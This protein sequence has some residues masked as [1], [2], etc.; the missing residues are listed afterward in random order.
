MGG[1]TPRGGFSL[2]ASIA[3][4]GFTRERLAAV[5]VAVLVAGC[6][7]SGTAD[8]GA[9]PEAGSRDAGGAI[10]AGATADAGADGGAD[11]GAACA[12]GSFTDA[13]FDEC[14][15]NV[16]GATF[17]DMCNTCADCIPY[18]GPG[19]TRAR[20][21]HK[22]PADFC[23]KPCASDADCAGGRLPQYVRCELIRDG[24][25]CGVPPF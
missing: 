20:C 2:I 4:A 22:G 15:G 16:S 23:L 25:Y 17:Q 13:G 9:I 24:C 3:T 11:A 14:A 12:A 1:A 19:G 5:G 8:A 21:A 10:D 18:A 7:A 6:A